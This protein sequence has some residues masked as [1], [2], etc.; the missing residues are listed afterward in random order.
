M[1]EKEKPKEKTPEEI[2]RE[3]EQKQNEYLSNL[4]TFAYGGVAGNAL[5]K[6]DF[7]SAHISLEKLASDMGLDKDNRLE[8]FLKG[9]YATQDSIKVAASIY[10]NRYETSRSQ[11]TASNLLKSYDEYLEKY[12]GDLKGKAVEEINKFKDTEYGKIRDKYLAAD[13]IIKSKTSNFTKEQKER[14]KKELEKYGKVVT[15]LEI[16]NKAY[17]RK[18][19]NSVDEATD[20]NILKQIYSEDKPDTEGQKPNKAGK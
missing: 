18:Y 8:G 2:K 13:E 9:T 6:E 17:L 19:E 16:L 5:A 11:L 10:A 7:N 20:I 12:L 1:A 3:Y 14:A 15:T 4:K